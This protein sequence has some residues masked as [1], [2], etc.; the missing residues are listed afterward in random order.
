VEMS[1]GQMQEDVRLALEGSVP[2]DGYFRLGGGIPEVDEI[3]KK[4]E[5]YG[6]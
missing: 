3:V 1:A 4:V 2:V 6:K 5:N